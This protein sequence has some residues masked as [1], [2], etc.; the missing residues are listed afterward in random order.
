MRS[1][2]NVKFYLVGVTRVSFDFE[3]S[4]LGGGQVKRMKARL[5]KARLPSCVGFLFFCVSLGYVSV[6]LLF[7]G[8]CFYEGSTFEAHAAHFCPMSKVV[9]TVIV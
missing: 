8:N 5:M 1:L 9:L 7:S 4:A 6:V 2:R 3:S